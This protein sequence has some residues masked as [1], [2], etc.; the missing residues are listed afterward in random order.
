MTEFW[1]TEFVRSVSHTTTFWVEPVFLSSWWL[2][3]LNDFCMLP[4]QGFLSVKTFSG[5]PAISEITHLTSSHK[6]ICFRS[7]KG[8]KKKRKKPC[9]HIRPFQVAFK[10]FVFCLVLSCQ[11]YCSFAFHISEQDNVLGV[12]TRYW[13]PELKTEPYLHFLLYL[14]GVSQQCCVSSCLEDISFPDKVWYLLVIKVYHRVNP[15][16]AKQNAL[17]LFQ[18]I[19]TG[20]AKMFKGKC[21]E[22]ML[23]QQRV[24]T[25]S[26]TICSGLLFIVSIYSGKILLGT[27]L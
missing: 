17:V 20:R 12:L 10:S 24:V 19:C 8:R 22:W 18:F 26:I 11:C 27:D 21:W 7:T 15:V 14:M 1:E 6:W 4:S 13:T 16:P 2:S 3:L 9:V 25:D 5:T 23:V